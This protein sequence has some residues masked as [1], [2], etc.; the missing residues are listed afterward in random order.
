MSETDYLI[1]LCAF[2][3]LKIEELCIVMILLFF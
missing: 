1:L 3:V 2:R